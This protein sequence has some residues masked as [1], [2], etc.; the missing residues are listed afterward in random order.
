MNTNRA[1]NRDVRILK[2]LD[3]ISR[4]AAHLF[5]EAA[6]QAI[7]GRGRF[8]AAFSGG[9]TPM[10]LYR[11]LAVEPHRARVDW[12]RTH[13]FWGDERCVPPDDPG[14]C[15]GQAK[16]VLLDHVAIPAENV[17]R[18]EST[19]EPA[20]A[21][22]D[23]ARRLKGFASPPLD[24]PR[25]DLVLLGMGDD[26]HTASLFPGSPLEAAAP[27]MAVT[28]HY[29]DRPANRVTLTPPV[30]NAARRIL[31]LVSG[32]SKADAL[33]NVLFGDY[34]PVNLP[35][36]RIDPSDGQVTWLVDAAAGSK[37]GPHIQP[38]S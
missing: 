26:A 21:A 11:L 6:G 12:T 29:Q 31:F 22:M 19:L 28:A 24:W 3:E 7:A 13:V 25:L 2:D 36:Q 34:H 5:A 16:S 15:Y 18:I 32:A 27:T 9:N 38:L 30:I 8:L 4:A 10:G 33:V 37:I 14:N 17:H 20:A 1:L 35:A 23:Y